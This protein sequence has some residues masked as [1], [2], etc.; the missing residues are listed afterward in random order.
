MHSMNLLQGYREVR[1]VRPKNLIYEL[2][3]ELKQNAV[4]IMTM[5]GGGNFGHLA[6][7]LSNVDYLLHTGVPFPLP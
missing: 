3:K 5:L 1:I 6:L 2:E 4:L 7:L